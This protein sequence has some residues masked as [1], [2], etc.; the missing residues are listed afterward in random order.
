MSA[1]I[2][3]NCNTTNP[4]EANYCR[5]C[6]SK[7]EEKPFAQT[8]DGP[9]HKKDNINTSSS[10]NTSLWVFL[11][12]LIITTIILGISLAN[13]FEDLEREQRK[14]TNLEKQIKELESVLQQKKKDLNELNSYFSDIPF[15]ITDVQVANTY[16]DGTIET[17]YGYR[18]YNSNTMYLKPK[19]KYIGL[20]SGY[21]KLRVKLYDSY[22]NLSK[23]TYQNN[24]SPDDC[25]YADDFYL[26]KG[27]NEHNLVGWGNEN[28]GH[29]QRGEYRFEIWY[30]NKCQYSKSFTIY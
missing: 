6:G 20:S 14:H 8:H 3:S 1:K 19:I 28:K 23:G 2:C 18:I 29:W 9:I 5:H 10:S 16:K 24:P 7:F 13:S 25:S 11:I 21:R 17:N 12:L 30:N 4:P 27:K 22:G 26:S 15:I